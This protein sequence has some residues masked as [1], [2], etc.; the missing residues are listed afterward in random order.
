MRGRARSGTIILGLLLGATLFLGGCAS[1]PKHSK[2]TIHVVRPGENG[3]MLTD[4]PFV[5]SKEHLAGFYIIN[6][7][8]L[9]AAL[10]WAKKVTDCIGNVIEVR[11]FGGTGKA[12]DNMPG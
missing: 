8:D 5:E 6:A 9:D 3:P 2:G 12:V 11:P 10:E 4:G 1:T 7:T